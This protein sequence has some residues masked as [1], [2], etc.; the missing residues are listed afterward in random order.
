MKLILI[1]ILL[2]FFIYVLSAKKE[3]FYPDLKITKCRNKNKF[4]FFEKLREY[5]Y[6]TRESNFGTFFK[7]CDDRIQVDIKR[8]AFRD[9]ANFDTKEMSV[10]NLKYQCNNLA[11]KQC[12]FNY[13]IP[14]LNVDC[15][16]D[17]FNWC[18]DAYNNDETT[19]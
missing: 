1:A 14:S 5:V 19:E 4:D 17:Y 15:Y 3:Q 9:E 10:N 2:V 8:K 7:G 16:N 18:V 12:M 11:N 13:N 6:E